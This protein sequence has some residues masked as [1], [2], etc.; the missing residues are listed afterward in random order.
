MSKVYNYQLFYIAKFVE[1]EF[2]TPLLMKLQLPML[3][4]WVRNFGHLVILLPI[5]PIT[6][7]CCNYAY[8]YLSQYR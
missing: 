2:C 5:Q 7:I 3:T 1:A 6:H 8:M 4:I